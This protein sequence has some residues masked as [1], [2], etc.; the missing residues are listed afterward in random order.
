MQKQNEE[1]L[2]QNEALSRGQSHT[3]TESQIISYS[4]V[5]LPQTQFVAYSPSPVSKKHI[6]KSFNKYSNH[7]IQQMNH[8]SIQPTIFDLEE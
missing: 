1:L 2:E 7:N 3:M 5:G 4:P 6:A 8:I